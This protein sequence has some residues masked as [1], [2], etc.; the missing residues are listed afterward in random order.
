MYFDR[1]YYGEK[2]LPQWSAVVPF[3]CCVFNGGHP[4]T[5]PVDVIR[6]KSYVDSF[7][8]STGVPVR[9]SINKL[10]FVPKWIMAGLVG[11]FDQKR[12]RSGSAGES[13][14]PVVLFDCFM[15]RSPISPM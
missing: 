8:G 9:V 5:I 4:R 15:H 3:S 12:R 10:C 11:M 6:V 1:H 2:L 13:H 7:L 14:I